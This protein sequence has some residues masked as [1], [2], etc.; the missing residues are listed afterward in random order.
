M[1]LLVAG[2]VPVALLLA[3][4]LIAWP[5]LMDPDGAVALVWMVLGLPPMVVA[6]ILATSA[7]LDA[8]RDDLARAEHEADL[9]FRTYWAAPDR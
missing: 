1:S 4:I 2:W 3:L 7:W 5:P 9:R 8:C 6:W